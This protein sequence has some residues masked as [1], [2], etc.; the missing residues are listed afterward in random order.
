MGLG[1]IVGD[2]FQSQCLIVNS[3]PR[4][5]D[6]LTADSGEMVAKRGRRLA[7]ATPPKFLPWAAVQER[8][9]IGIS[10]ISGDNP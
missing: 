2:S 4:R 10:A 6:Q 7:R 8:N 1:D 9:P 5:H 3:A